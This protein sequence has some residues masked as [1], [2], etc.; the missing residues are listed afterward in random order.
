MLDVTGGTPSPTP[1]CSTGDTEGTLVSTATKGFDLDTE[2]KLFLLTFG[3]LASTLLPS[4][5]LFALS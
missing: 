4:F 3:V 5:V 2:T 1:P